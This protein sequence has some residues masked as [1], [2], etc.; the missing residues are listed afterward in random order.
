MLNYA[1][2]FSDLPVSRKL[3]DNLLK[4][5]DIHARPVKSHT[6]ITNVSFEFYIE[7]LVDIDI[8]TGSVILDGAIYL[9]WV[10]EHLVWNPADY[11]NIKEFRFD[12]EDI[13]KPDISILDSST[14]DNAFST[15]TKA[16]IHV[17]ASGSVYWYQTVTAISHCEF[18]LTNFPF[19][20]HSCNQWFSTWTYDINAVNITLFSSAYNNNGV[21][22]CAYGPYFVNPHWTMT[23]PECYIHIYREGIYISVNFRVTR[24]LPNYKYYLQIPY[25]AATLFAIVAFILPIGSNQRLVFSGFSLLI[26]TMLLIFIGYS[27]GFQSIGSPYA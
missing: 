13:W 12:E 26:L 7:Q 2:S 21:H 5:Y 18:D 11:G 1:E 23:T 19:D 3:R 9:H 16:P 15:V 24:R 17:N 27:L 25:A 8:T 10:D 6:T 4:D 14:N 20:E 22:S